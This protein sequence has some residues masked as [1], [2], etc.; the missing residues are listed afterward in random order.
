MPEPSTVS[1]FSAPP[2]AS[3]RLRE[4]DW[5]RG[6]VMVLMTIDHASSSFNPGRLMS[7][8]AFMYKPGTPLPYDQFFTRWITHLCAPTFVFLAGAALSLSVARR[9][10]AGEP[11]GKTDRFIITRGLIIFALDPLWM[12]LAFTPGSV[13]FQVLYAIGVSMVCMALLRRLP[14]PAL[15][16]SG[17]LLIAGSEALAGLVLWLSG[18]GRSIAGALLVT[19]G[20]VG[21]KLMVAYPLLP[22]LAM[23]M[24][25]WAFGSYLV[26]KPEERRVRATLTAAGAL[27]LLVFAVVR[28]LNGYGNM[29]LARDDGSIVQWL[30][31]SKYPPSLSYT[32]LELGI[33]AVLLALFLEL[34][35]RA[36]DRPA[37]PLR[38]LGVFGG[39]A[40]FYYVLHTHVMKLA[41]L[42][43]GKP[44][45]GATYAG[46]AVTLLG[47]YP[48]CRA[49]QRYKAAHPESLARFI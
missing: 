20:P 8:S 10:A 46:A 38:V 41:A 14:A 48:L 35:R 9:A 47:L 16:G 42:V 36:G 33:M 17:A 15:L 22:W 40:L 19:G 32:A 4:I 24:V 12:S 18:G 3:G 2:A 28:G 1:A 27:S 26:A 23:M 34:R 31:V 39:V 49:Y 44:G 37:L 21:G 13:L 6:L 43:I 30:H 29:R 5:L 11:A 45:L 25:G 7:D